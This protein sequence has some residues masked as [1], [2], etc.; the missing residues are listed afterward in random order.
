MKFLTQT[1]ALAVTA[2]LLAT[3]S[4][5][6][7][8]TNGLT[9]AGGCPSAEDA[10]FCDN[11]GNP[12]ELNVSILLG[13]DEDKV[14]FIGQ[15]SPDGLSSA[16][17]ITFDNGFDFDT[18]DFS[19]GWTVS[20]TSITHLAFKADGFYILADIGGNTSGTWSTNIDD[21]LP[22]YLGVTCPVG[23]CSVERLYT[24]GLGTEASPADFLDVN[25]TGGVPL[26]SSVNAYNVVPIPAALWLFGS[27]LG[28]L[29][30]MRRKS[31]A[32]K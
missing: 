13:V 14:H 3:G 24:A 32:A 18:P 10:P 17:T 5:F 7:A 21:W 15:E 23:I 26:L 19:G 9:F 2:L 25:G 12:D 31:I 20:D 4:A 16:F 29:G 22:D 30:W 8:T 27:G 6:A 28:L 1:A 11:S